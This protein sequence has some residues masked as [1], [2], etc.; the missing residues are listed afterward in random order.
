MTINY[1]KEY[2][3]SLLAYISYANM[4]GS[5]DGDVQW[6]NLVNMDLLDPLNTEIF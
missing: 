2:I 5:K 6:E 1:K 3:N 4:N